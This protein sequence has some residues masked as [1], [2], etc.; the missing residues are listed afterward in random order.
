[1]G[2]QDD[3]VA[4]GGWQSDPVVPS[5]GTRLYSPNPDAPTSYGAPPGTYQNGVRIGDNSGDINPY[6]VVGQFAQGNNDAWAGTLGY[7]VD[8]VN[9]GAKALGMQTSDTPVLGSQS[10]KNIFDYIS[11]LPARYREGVRNAN[12]GGGSPDAFGDSRTARF[13]AQGPAERIANAVGSAVGNTT[14]TVLPAGL[15]SRASTAG[16]VPQLVADALKANP[17]AQTAYTA[18]GNVVG[19]ETGDPRLGALTTM[20][21]PLLTHGAQRT[22]S[23]APAVPGSDE[24]ER[25]ALLEYGRQNDLGPLTAGKILDSKGLQVIESAS[26]KLPLPLIGGRVARTEAA[27]RSAF[28][29]AAIAKAGGSGTAVTPG[30]L[31]DND[32]RIGKMFDAFKGETVNV[33]P[34]FGNDLAKARADFSKQLESQIPASIMSKIDELTTAPAS[35]AQSGN[36]TA[37]IDGETFQNIRSKLSKA[38]SKSS[39]TD[40]EALGATIDAL[41]SLAERSLPK[42]VVDKYVMARQQWRNNLA[43]KASVAANNADTAVGNM[44]PAAFGR[45]SRG[46][47]D[48]ARLGQ[49]GNAFVGDKAPNSSGTA[50]HNVANHMLGGG[51][52]AGGLEAYHNGM[53]TPHL[54]IPAAIAA[55]VPYAFELGMNN[56]VT[57]AALLA[58]YRNAT[59]SYVTPSLVGASVLD[60]LKQLR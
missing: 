29:G 20:A 40:T 47:P 10:F 57:R 43:L 31:A 24:A 21:L 42:D 46:N 35:L 19:S 28:Q 7:P 44:S 58:R 14:S 55:S 11:T 52:V 34:Q 12:G 36:P 37:A 2:W 23:A 33:D 56:P 1:M 26:S 15:I 32:A 59:P 5:Q 54:A 30:L 48:L 13:E 18:A 6:R 27:N 9:S 41:D 8:L 38:I 50:S 49:Y 45:A 60:A 39:G 53:M 25:R 17:I 3:P 4:G 51:L 22:V 16:S